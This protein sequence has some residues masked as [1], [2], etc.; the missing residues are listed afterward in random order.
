MSS[1]NHNAHAR[2]SSDEKDVY[3]FYDLTWSARDSSWSADWS[4]FSHTIEVKKKSTGKG[5]KTGST[6][7]F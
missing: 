6:L 3:N 2:Y 1:L 7:D 5:G 4:C